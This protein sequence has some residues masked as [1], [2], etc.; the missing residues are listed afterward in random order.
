M[1]SCFI[2]LIFDNQLQVDIKTNRKN[3]KNFMA[4]EK[5][6]KQS[7]SHTLWKSQI[8]FHTPSFAKSYAKLKRVCEPISQP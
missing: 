7:I 6:E 2:Y 3:L 4:E 8:S 1:I 5:P